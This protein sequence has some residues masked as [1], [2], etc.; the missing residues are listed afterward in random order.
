MAMLPPGLRGSFPA[1]F[2]ASSSRPR[3][4]PHELPCGLEGDLWF[5]WAHTALALQ[6]E[7]LTAPQ[8]PHVSF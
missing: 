4:K 1:L 3:D 5:P 6:E 8:G 7:G 2:A